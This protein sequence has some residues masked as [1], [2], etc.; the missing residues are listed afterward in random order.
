MRLLSWWHNSWDRIIKCKMYTVCKIRYSLTSCTAAQE[1]TQKQSV[2]LHFSLGQTLEQ[3]HSWSIIIKYPP[4]TILDLEL[5]VCVGTRSR[6]TQL[7]LNRVIRVFLTSDACSALIPNLYWLVLWLICLSPT[8]GKCH[9]HY[10]GQCFHLVPK[11]S[12]TVF[13]SCRLLKGCED[14][15]EALEEKKKKAQKHFSVH[16]SN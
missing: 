7:K 12:W 6:M 4:P 5:A 11:C 8:E 15:S 13:I 3:H 14:N 9:D 1:S 10:A 16:D 2:Y